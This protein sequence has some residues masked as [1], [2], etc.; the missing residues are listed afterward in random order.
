MTDYENYNLTLKQKMKLV[1]SWIEGGYYQLTKQVLK[2]L[3]YKRTHYG[4]KPILSIDG[5]REELIKAVLKGAPYFAGRFGTTECSTLVK[6]WQQRAGFVKDYKGWVE[7]ICTYSGFFP[8]SDML[9]DKW[10]QQETEC[11][12]YVDMLGVMN[13]KCEGWIVDTFCPENAKLMPNGGLGSAQHGWTWCLEGKK[14][15][16]IH[17]MAETI[18][19]QYKKRELLYQHIDEKYPL[20]AFELQTLKAVQTIADQTDDRFSDWFAAL[21]YMTEEVRKRDFDVALIG[22][23]AYGFQLGARIKQMGK[24]AIH[25]GGSLQTLFG[26]KGKRW[27]NDSYMKNVYN[28]YWVYPDEKDKPAGAYKVE[29]GCYWN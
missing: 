13:T 4:R 18:E 20:P 22:C 29:G 14:V 5:G 15:L 23:G 1:A 7:S 27:D 19:Q 11:C 2:P 26:I 25:M 24:I 21:D 28:E 16:V 8:A 6:Y 17:P 12:A 3:R 9:V 10:A